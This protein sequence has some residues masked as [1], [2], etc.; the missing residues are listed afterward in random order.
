MVCTGSLDIYDIKSGYGILVA[1]RGNLALAVY[2][3]GTMAKYPSR[4]IRRIRMHIL[5]PTRNNYDVWEVTTD[6]LISFVRHDV[7]P[8]IDRVNRGEG[9]YYAGDHCRYCRGR[10]FCRFRARFLLAP[11]VEDF[12]ALS[13]SNLPE[14]S[15]MQIAALLDHL[16]TAKRW[17]EDLRFTIIDLLEAGVTI[18]GLMLR[19]RARERFFDP[20]DQ[21]TVAEILRTIGIDPYKRELLRPIDIERAL[22]ALRYTQLFGK[23]EQKKKYAT[24]VPTP[25]PTPPE[26][27]IRVM[28]QEV[29]GNV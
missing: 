1:A 21:E 20:A 29:A 8:A 7:I 17:Q 16:S 11:L 27:A 15:D 28:E 19:Y 26:E 5:Q 9:T 2:A 24:V 14:I 23:Y 22:G 25:E 3:L 4:N 6:E 12:R 13:S 18:P 10:D